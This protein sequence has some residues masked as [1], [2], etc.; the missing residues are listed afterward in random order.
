ME[1]YFSLQRTTQDLEI[2]DPIDTVRSQ[3][4]YRFSSIISGRSQ[5]AVESKK[6]RTLP[7]SS[8]NK[9]EF[10]EFGAIDV[11]TVCRMWELTRDRDGRI[12]IVRRE[13]GQGSN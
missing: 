5:N 8:I 1:L 9:K 6:L 13:R 3:K 4:L 7:Y 10:I 12:Q 2:D 11:I